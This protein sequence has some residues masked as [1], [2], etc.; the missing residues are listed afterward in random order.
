MRIDSF[1]SLYGPGLLS[2][3]IG[4]LFIRILTWV[5]G[6]IG[7][8]AVL[9]RVADTLAERMQEAARQHGSGAEPDREPE[10]RTTDP[11][12]PGHV[13]K[14]KPKQTPTVRRMR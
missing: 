14:P 3:V 10:P 1:V 11:S 7:S 6:R 12:K 4:A 13:H 8:G 5:R 2:V 9:G